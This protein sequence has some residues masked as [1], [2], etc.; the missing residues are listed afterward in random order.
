ML[1][2][3]D[4]IGRERIGICCSMAI[5]W[6]MLIKVDSTILIN[7]TMLIP[8]RSLSPNTAFDAKEFLSTER[9][10][11]FKG[12]SRRA[13]CQ[14]EGVYIYIYINIL[15]VLHVYVYVCDVL[16]PT[17]CHVIQSSTSSLPLKIAWQASCSFRH[18]F[19]GPEEELYSLTF[20]HLVKALLSTAM[21]NVWRLVFVILWFWFVFLLADGFW[22]SSLTDMILEA[23]SGGIC[24]IIYLILGHYQMIHRLTT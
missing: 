1:W 19:E 15:H 10:Y 13:T 9:L 6:N 7:D 21:K 18:Y 8:K 11:Y 4:T 3:T 20:V 22:A 5:I 14:V 17:Y 16:I 23:L 12:I 24:S 2:R